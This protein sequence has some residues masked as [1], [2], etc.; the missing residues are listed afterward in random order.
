[1]KYEDAKKLCIDLIDCEGEE[2]VVNILKAKGFWDNSDCWRYYGDDELN[3][4]RAGNQQAR[5]DFAVNEKLVNTIDSR[6][7]L[8]CMLTGINPEDPAAPPS[9]RE[10]VNRFIEKTWTGTLKVSG[11]RVEDYL[12][13]C[14]RT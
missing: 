5:S 6:L 9:M 3:W 8:E 14:Y 1:L 2:E 12:G 11:G 7:M 10:A 4:N 13:I